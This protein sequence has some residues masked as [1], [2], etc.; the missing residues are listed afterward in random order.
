MQ[1]SQAV[2]VPSEAPSFHQVQAAKQSPDNSKLS[3]RHELQ[4]MP[5]KRVPMQRLLLRDRQSVTRLRHPSKTRF[6]A[7]ATNTKLTLPALKQREQQHSFWAAEAITKG[8][9]D[10][11]SSTQRVDTLPC[12]RRVAFAIEPIPSPQPI[13]AAQCRP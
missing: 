5:A 6:I 3:H 2:N 11:G 4:R 8:K 9:T 12:S 1:C 7:I 10:A 13:I